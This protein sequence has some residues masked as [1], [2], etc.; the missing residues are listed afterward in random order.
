[1]LVSLLNFAIVVTACRLWFML[2][3][4]CKSFNE[5][6]NR[7]ILKINENLSL[8]Y[9]VLYVVI[10]SDYYEFMRIDIDYRLFLQLNKSNS[11]NYLIKQK[12]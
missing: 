1:M 8:Y 7:K 9:S 6:Y 12:K 4:L 3:F 2:C 10:T 5:D 11:F